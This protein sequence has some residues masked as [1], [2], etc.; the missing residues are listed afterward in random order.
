MFDLIVIGAGPAGLSAAI[1]A[2]RGGL[3]T[4][5]FDKG[6]YGGQVTQT[7]EVE[8]Y[9]AIR[10]ISGMD[11]SDDLY[12]QAVALGA[13]VRLEEV[14]SVDFG[15]KRKRVRTS[16]GELVEAK[17]VI[18]ANG[19]ERRRLGCPGEERFLGRGGS[20]CATCD[21]AFFKGKPVAVV[22]GGN[23]ALE[24]AL[25][26]FKT[27]SE[28]HLIHRRETFQGDRVLSDAVL[29]NGGIV[30]HI[31]CE[32]EEILGEENVSSV[33]IVDRSTGEKSELV[34][35]GLFVAIGLEPRN[36]LFEGMLD[37]DGRGYIA[38]DESCATNLEGVFAAGGTRTKLLRQI[39]TAAADGAVAAFQAGNYIN[40]VWRE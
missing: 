8:N 3:S 35:N 5:V 14:R 33:R 10:K 29:A 34:V 11:F 9:P 39:V 6:F 19:V 16:S 25:F 31:P 30:R 13:Q 36:G 32:V 18:V 38:A 4:V 12:G 2:L 21:G 28:V 7:P 26:L 15:G 37:L 20:Y 23:T 24:D 22:G 1:Y 40:A 17:A 27:C